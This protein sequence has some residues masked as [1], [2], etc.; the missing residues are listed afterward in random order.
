M[1]AESFPPSFRLLLSSLVPFNMPKYLL[2]EAPEAE[3]KLGFL[4]LSLFVHR[5]LFADYYLE[6]AESWQTKAGKGAFT[7]LELLYLPQVVFLCW[8][9]YKDTITVL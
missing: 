7:L 9:S 4:T 5:F 3:G 1:S 2:A 8:L 6:R